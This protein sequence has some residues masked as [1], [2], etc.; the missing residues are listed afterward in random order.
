MVDLNSQKAL[1]LELNAFNKIIFQV[2]TIEGITYCALRLMSQKTKL[3][4][5]FQ[6]VSRPVFSRYVVFTLYLNIIYI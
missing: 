1:N 3:L 2:V 5:P 6:T 4:P